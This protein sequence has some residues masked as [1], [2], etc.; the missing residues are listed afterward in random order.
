[1]MMVAFHFDIVIGK[2]PDAAHDATLADALVE[3]TPELGVW[4]YI[5]ATIS[6]LWL[7]HFEVHQHR[8]A[9]RRLRIAAHANGSLKLGTRI[10]SARNM[11]GVHF[12]YI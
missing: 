11:G 3:T 7:T 2:T 8:E 6:S 9:L 10:S 1:M 4:L 5:L 12:I